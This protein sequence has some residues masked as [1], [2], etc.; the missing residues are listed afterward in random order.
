MKLFQMVVICV[1]AMALSMFVLAGCEGAGGDNINS[2]EGDGYVNGEETSG[3]LKAGLVIAKAPNDFIG[4]FSFNGEVGCTNVSVC[5]FEETGMVEIEFVSKDK[6]F[7]TKYATAN[8]DKTLEIYWDKPGDWGLAPNGWYRDEENDT[9][10]EAKTTAT[11]GQIMLKWVP[12]T[13]LGA[14][15]G[16]TFKWNDG[17]GDTTSG[18]ISLDIKTIN[19]HK[20]YSTGVEVDRILVLVE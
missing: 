17:E 2:S 19:L 11:D 14:V 10:G 20:T 18:T 7:L 6:L 12:M 16:D 8:P 15:N 1:I 9:E 3:V 5:E 13:I 4:D